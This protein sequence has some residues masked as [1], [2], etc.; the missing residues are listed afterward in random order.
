MLLVRYHF[1]NR[2][3]G[4]AISHFEELGSRGVSVGCEA[5]FRYHLSL[6]FDHAIH[7]ADVPVKKLVIFGI[8]NFARM[9]HYFFDGDSDYQ[10]EAFV[11]DGEFMQQD[12]FQGLP[13]VAYEDLQHLY[14]PDDFE[15]FVAM[16]LRDVN[17][18]RKEKIEAAEAAGYR[19]AS[20]TS[21]KATLHPDLTVEPHTWIME[22]AHIHPFAKIGRGSIIWSR[23]TIGFQSS[24]GDYCWISAGLVGESVTVGD[25]T[26]IGLGATVASFVNVGKSN[27]I[28]AGAVIHNDTNDFEIY[29]GPHSKPSRVP[30]TRFGKFNG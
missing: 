4:K 17:Q 19:L 30:S 20:Y 27:L 6:T 21:T 5:E 13:V 11:V 1:L 3:A 16:G 12:Q 24:I 22:Q 9:A 14:P 2:T 23:S 15:L 7:S 28:G 18:K 8:G 10:T 29:K 25:C 26:F